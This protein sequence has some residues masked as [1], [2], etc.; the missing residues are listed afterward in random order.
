MLYQ[1]QKRNRH[2]QYLSIVSPNLL[3]FHESSSYQMN[4]LPML[5]TLVH[6]AKVSQLLMS[7]PG[8]QENV[9]PASIPRIMSQTEELF[10]SFF[11][12][13]L[14]LSNTS[15]AL[16]SLRKLFTK[17][18]LQVYCYLHFY[19]YYYQQRIIIILQVY[20]FYIKLLQESSLSM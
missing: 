4:L 15:V 5:P 9:L 8:Q 11:S 12:A 2:D 20:K 6:P 7:Q 17:K 10:V 14:V 16:F 19:S 3:I 13:L 1:K 18:L